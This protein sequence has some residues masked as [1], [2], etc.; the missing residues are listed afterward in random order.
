LS[1]PDTHAAK[2]GIVY[3]GVNLKVIED[4]E[5]WLYVESPLGRRGW[6]LKEWIQE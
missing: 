4:K 1:A 2:S 6:I 5:A 3:P